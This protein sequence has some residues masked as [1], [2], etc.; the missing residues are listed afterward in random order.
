MTAHWG[1]EDPAAVE[2]SGIEKER[3]FVQAFRY[4]KN[5]MGA[6]LALPLTSLD[7]ASLRTRLREIGHREGATTRRPDVA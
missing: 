1:I 4:L 3:A 7:A 2:G 6:F 5:R